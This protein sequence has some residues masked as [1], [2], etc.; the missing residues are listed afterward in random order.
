MEPQ[1]GSSTRRG[2]LR[3]AGTAMAGGVILG[4]A[5]ADRPYD[6]QP[7]HVT[8]DGYSEAP[9]ALEQYQPRVVTRAL[10]ITPDAMYCWRATSA[11]YN[12]SAWYAY[13]MWYPA[14]QEGATNADS[15]VPDREPIIVEVNEDTGE[16]VRVLFDRLHYFTVATTPTTDRPR[17]HAINPW[18]NYRET[19]EEGTLV[20][21]RD[22]H[23]RYEEW[24]TL[25]WTV[26]QR[27]VVDPP[28]VTSRGHWWPANDLGFSSTALSTRAVLALRDAGLEVPIPGRQT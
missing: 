23:D 6:R 1:R 3:L 18:H 9:D 7:S 4:T 15:H 12:G 14:G 17:L 5:A 28:H 26:D 22:M 27:S 24:L 16:L 13:W 8:L 11:E 10:D 21:L 20:E 2:F 25:N 19:T